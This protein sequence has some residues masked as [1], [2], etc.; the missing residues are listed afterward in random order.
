MQGVQTTLPIGSI[1]HGRYRIDGLL[2]KGGF[3]AVYRVQDQR[4]KGNLFALK[5]VINPTEEERERFAFE[6]SVLKRLDH[7]ALP[8][9]YQEFENPQTQRSYMLMDFVDG[10]NLEKL[11]LQQPAKRFPLQRVLQLMA[12]IFSAVSY[13]HSQQPPI[14]HRDIKPANIIVPKDS[15]GAVLVDLGIAKEYSKE[16]PTSTIRHSSPGYGAPEQYSYGTNPR[17]DIYGLA[18]TLYV[19]LTGVVPTDAFYRMT[20]LGSKNIDP[21]EAIRSLAPWVPP[22]IGAAIM[23]ALAI[24]SNDRFST[25]DEFWQAI[26]EVNLTDA[27]V[28]STAPSDTTEKSPTLGSQ[29]PEEASGTE[30]TTVVYPIQAANDRLYLA[31]SGRKQRS[32]SWLSIVVLLVLLLLVGSLVFAASIFARGQFVPLAGKTTPGASGQ[33]VIA[34]VRPT[35]IPTATPTLRPTATPTP[36]STAT[37]TPTAIPT[38]VPV[39]TYPQLQNHYHGSISNQSTSPQTNTSMDLSNIQQSTNAASIRGYFTVGPELLGNGNFTGF[40]TQKNYIQFQ[41]DSYNGLSPLLFIGTIQA[42]NSMQGTYC[43]AV[44]SAGKY[45][46]DKN[47]GGYGVWQLDAP[48]R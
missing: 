42:D 31:R 14:I 48:A 17:T 13:L 28:L 7:S 2:G 47:V 33:K 36:I 23:H 29:A 3:G 1:L 38:P 12:P 19:L 26:Q 39:L 40:V 11:R 20:Q 15:Q 18:A 6:C 41:V 5:E 45:Q 25:V 4:V 10:P 37:P 27:L 35:P 24:T 34:T 30:V 22:R 8:R 16:G 43:S 9:V 44:Q 32:V 21:L 46:C